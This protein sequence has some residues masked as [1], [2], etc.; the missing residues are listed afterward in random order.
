VTSNKYIIRVALSEDINTPFIWFSSLPCDSREIAKITNIDK[1][2]S[3]WCE[4]V[5]AIENFIERYNRNQRTININADTPF[6][7]INEWYR[8]KLCLIKNTQSNIEINISRKPH[9]I[10][11]LLASYK[12]PDN[13]VRLAADLAFVSVFLG[14][15]GLILGFISLCN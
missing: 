7:V 10:K 6:I 13:T 14:A 2:Q 4:V 15:I 12:H 5:T 11:Q 3:V 9:F 1:S 8:E